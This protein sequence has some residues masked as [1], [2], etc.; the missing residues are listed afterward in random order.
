[1]DTNGNKIPLFP[2]KKL[3]FNA[4]EYWIIE[5]CPYLKCKF[6]SPKIIFSLFIIFVNGKWYNP[7]SGLYTVSRRIK[8]KQNKDEVIRITISFFVKVFFLTKKNTN[9]KIIIKVFKFTL[10]G[11]KKL[12]I[13]AKNEIYIK[14]VMAVSEKFFRLYTS[15][16]LN[17]FPNII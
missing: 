2:K 14:P 6:V 4:D 11:R 15:V 7:A 13:K 10:R 9:I 5:I 17:N 3:L 12:I 1:M 8:K 16:L